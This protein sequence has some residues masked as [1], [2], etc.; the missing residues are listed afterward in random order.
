MDILSKLNTRY[1]TKIFD[2]KKKV[3]EADMDKL[4]EAIRLS[5]S[6]FGLQPYKVLVVEDPAIRA[7]LRKAAWDQPQIT[8]ASALLVFAANFETSAET[9]DE[10]VDLVS[11]TRN[12][13]KDA[14]SGYSDMMKGTIQ[15]QNPEQ[16][17][18]WVSKQAYIA[19]GFGLVSAA[20]LDIDACPMEGFSPSD[21]DRILDINK[22]GLK[23]KV[24]MAVGYRSDEDKYQHLAKVRQKKE[25]LFIKF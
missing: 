24:I 12:I 25:D 10:F 17:D 6:S 16:I 9:V 21:F 19:L 1:A 22:L 3:S 15:S 11:H 14:L 20:V 2:P 18:T 4:L 13:P 7:E 8:D 5:A 23:S